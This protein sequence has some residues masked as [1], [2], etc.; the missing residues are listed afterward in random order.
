MGSFFGLKP[1]V[2]RKKPALHFIQLNPSYNPPQILIF[3]P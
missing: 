3:A 2:D 1:F